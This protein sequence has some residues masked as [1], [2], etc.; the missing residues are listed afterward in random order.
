MGNYTN[1][2][3]LLSG[4]IINGALNM[5]NNTGSTL[6]LA[7][8]GSQSYSSTVNGTTT[9]NGSLLKQ[10][11]GN[12]TLNQNLNP[13]GGTVVS[14]GHLKVT[15]ALA[16]ATTVNA[17]AALGGNGTINGNVTVENLGTLYP[18]DP[19]VLTVNGNVAL[20]TGAK[21]AFSIANTSTPNLPQKVT[22]GIDYDQ[23]SIRDT[24]STGNLTIQSGA[25]LEILNLSFLQWNSVVYAPTGPNTDLTNYFV[26]SLQSGTTTGRFD[27]FSN[28]STSQAITYTGGIGEVTLDNTKV[29]ISYTGNAA[30]NSTLGGQ[31]IVLSA[32]AVPEPSTW[33]LILL[34]VGFV[35]LLQI[36]KHRIAK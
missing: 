23:I 5:G 15:A 9:F 19:A 16:G 34:G 33:V 7:G 20:N 12:W 28:G 3:T 27:L 26:F 36:R 4:G 32:Y 22:V 30:L 24:S 14:G 29:F 8:S 25:T 31:D 21:A 35:G 6:I 10:G 13:S 1:I 17:N 11:S 2:V 18:G